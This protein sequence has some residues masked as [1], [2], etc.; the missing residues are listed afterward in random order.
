[1]KT[2]YLL[3]L[4][5]ISVLCSGILSVSFIFTV[6]T[7]NIALNILLWYLGSATCIFLSPNIYRF[8]R[9]FIKK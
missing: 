4:L 5:L 9:I 3:K 7:P 1:M 8:L 2:S 6:G